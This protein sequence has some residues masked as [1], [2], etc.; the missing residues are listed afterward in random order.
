ME[1]CNLAGFEGGEKRPRARE[2]EKPPEPA[3]GREMHSSL[4]LQKVMQLG[5]HLNIR[6]VRRESDY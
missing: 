2:C 3:K 1:G 4:I 5:P 6:Y